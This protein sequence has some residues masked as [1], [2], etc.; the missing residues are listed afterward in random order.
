MA[1][2][3]ALTTLAVGIAEPRGLS[4]AVASASVYPRSTAVEYRNL[5]PTELV[6]QAIRRGE[7]QLSTSGALAVATGAHTGRSPKDK[8]VV[9]HG[10]LAGEIWWGDVNQPMEPEAFGLL[11]AD[12]VQHLSRSDRFRMDLAV[13]AD[14]AYRLP[15]R[16]L[17][18]SAW[19][20][21]FAR[22]LFL[23]GTSEESTQS[24]GWTILHAPSF[25]AD[26][27]RHGTRSRTAI[28]I[29]FEW[30]RVLIA[31][32]EYA[33]EIKKSMFTVLQGLLPG[34]GVATMHC[35]AN[36]G[37]AGDTALFFGLSG[38]GKTTLS[39]DPKRRLIGDDEHGWS[40]SGVFNFEGGC[41]AKTIG[42]SAAAEPE[43]F[44]AARRFSTVLENVVLDPDTRRPRFDDDSLTENTRAAY[45]LEA[46]QANAGGSGGHPSQILFLSADA[47]GVLPPVARLT[48]DQAQYWFLSGYT[49]K[50]AGTEKG[51]TSPEATFSACF[52]SPFL[53]LPPNR[54]ADLF[55]K[56]IEQHG[57]QVWLVNTGWTGGPYGVGARM[58]IAL[59]RSLVSAILAGS[60]DAAAFDRDPLFGFGV[61]RGLSGVPDD[62]LI[63]RRTWPN[64]ND[65]DR[66]ARRL[67]RSLAENFETYA[68]SVS[69]AV[70]SAGPAL[71]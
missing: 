17:T 37:A 13:G 60:L 61:P 44:S 26:P 39:T 58:P 20:A 31:G 69:V 3:S 54:Y 1:E 47:F 64:G 27:R 57:S 28:A 56:R 25:E 32:T 11:H 15:L 7:G 16:L 68:A 18:E 43:I 65:Y 33:G 63:P 12:L 51:I 24:E 49:S 55:G 50:L 48:P 4:L 53:P 21:L 67:A 45:R 71:T 2:R 34:R 6:E 14:A 52:G 22:N 62:V 30:Q 5:S 38:T 23:T 19:S 35:A 66:A 40:D 8:F 29:D 9:R 59:T 46:L 41:Y 36:E 10:D 42:L 70:R